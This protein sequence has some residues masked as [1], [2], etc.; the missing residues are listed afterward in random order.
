MRCWWWREREKLFYLLE[1]DSLLSPSLICTVCMPTIRE[2]KLEE[3]VG[4]GK[5]R[6]KNAHNYVTTQ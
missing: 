3:S 6:K 1:R 5:C 2:P 4:Q